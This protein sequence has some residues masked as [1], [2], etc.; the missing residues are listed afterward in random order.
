MTTSVILVVFH[1]HFQIDVFFWPP[2]QFINFYFLPISLRLIY[3]NSACLLWA[4]AL[5]SLKHNVSQ[6]W[7]RF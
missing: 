7:W 3:V 4:I 6:S 2:V 1:A 5:S